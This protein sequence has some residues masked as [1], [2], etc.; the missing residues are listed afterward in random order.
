MT[1]HFSTGKM[2]SSE[3]E[4]A[5]VRLEHALLLSVLRDDYLRR[6]SERVSIREPKTDTSP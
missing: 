3:V 5:F 6:F 2:N 4:A 1:T